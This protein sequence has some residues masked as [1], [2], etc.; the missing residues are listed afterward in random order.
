MG[1][2]RLGIPLKS[3]QDTETQ[4]D[5]Y[6]I[7]LFRQKTN[8]ALIDQFLH[9]VVARVRSKDEY[10]PDPNDVHHIGSD[11]VVLEWAGSH[12]FIED[13][14]SL[15]L[16]SERVAEKRAFFEFYHSTEY[17]A[18]DDDNAIKY[19]YFTTEVIE[20]EW[21]LAILDHPLLCELSHRQFLRRY[22]FWLS[23]YL[24][25]RI[26]R[27]ACKQNNILANLSLTGPAAIKIRNVRGAL[28]NCLLQ[29]A[30]GY[31]TQAEFEEF[32]GN[33][34]SYGFALT[35]EPDVPAESPSSDC[36]FD[37]SQTLFEDHDGPWLVI[38]TPSSTTTLDDHSDEMQKDEQD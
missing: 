28:R 38:S 23:I 24:D 19:R 6:M 31:C 20:N 3:R 37:C 5:I 9:S 12:W 7:F 36:L 34:Y 25:S 22:L 29:Y 27:L 16:D 26:E 18:D 17:E 33:A 15:L 32:I 8:A 14:I 4:L 1:M 2:S 35:Q 13:F 30:L 10:E 21:T 11:R